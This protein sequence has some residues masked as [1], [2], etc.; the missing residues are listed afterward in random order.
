MRSRAA[1][2]AGSV[3]PEAARQ[4]EA[5]FV[6]MMLQSM[7]A[8]GDVF[9]D[10]SDTTYRDMFDQQI[11]LEM[12]KGKGLGL[13]DVLTRQLAPADAAP[14]R[15]APEPAGKDFVSARQAAPPSLPAARFEVTAPDSAELLR[16]V[17]LPAW[18]SRSADPAG[19]AAARSWQRLAA[20]DARGIHPRHLAARAERRARSSAWIRGPS[21]RRRRSRPAGA[22]T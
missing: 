4:F 14:H 9:G 8:A 16:A 21:W 12:T 17:A 22:A 15:R 6:Q 2:D 10:G 3:T 18:I 20:G 5:L 19:S 11:S 1:T 7:R 13:A